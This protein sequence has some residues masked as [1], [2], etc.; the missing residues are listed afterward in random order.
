MA[1]P[2]A[3]PY[4]SPRATS[5]SLVLLDDIAHHPY[6]SERFIQSR[7]SPHYKGRWEVALMWSG[8]ASSLLFVLLAVVP[9]A[10]RGSITGKITDHDS[11]TVAGALVQAKH[12]STGTVFRATS[13]RTG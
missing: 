4:P 9:Q 3:L 2:E 5:E 8:I 12:N 6:N 13:S 1:R 7:P 10:Q 11:G